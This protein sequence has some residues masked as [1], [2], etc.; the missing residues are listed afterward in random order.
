M[1]TNT[2]VI[3]RLN[4]D[5]KNAS[6]LLSAK[7]AR[8][9]V[10]IYYSVQDFRMRADNQV[11]SLGDEEP[12]E[13]LSW[14]F[15]NMQKIEKDIKSALGVFAADYSVGQWLQ[16]ICGIGPVLSAG[17]LATFDI[18]GAKTAGHYWRFAGQDPTLEWASRDVAKK[19]VKEIMGEAK[20]VNDEHLSLAAD[21]VG[22]RPEQLQNIFDKVLNVKKNKKS[23][24]K[25]DLASVIS[26]RPWNSRLK[27]LCWKAGESFIKVQSRDSD[28]YGKLF[29][30]RKE[31]EI[32]KND[33]GE[34]SDQARK[35]LETTKI[36]KSTKA[37]KFYSEGR[38]PPDHINSRARR[39]AVKMFLSHLHH[40][41]Y[42]D[43]YQADP[44]VPFV[45]SKNCNEDHRHY[46][47]PPEIKTNGK[48]LRDLYR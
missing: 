11:R 47:P 15:G 10:D 48:S 6:R 31:Q 17:F 13:V 18:R 19:I 12:G 2:D 38:L 36:S 33:A 43:Y 7:E 26:M 28:I 8:Y 30:K 21:K 42:V 14:V 4:K 37:Y 44:P 20:I 27:V 35:K 46:I 1:E 29:V 22:R 40:I 5:L 32:R 39:Y 23:M 41:S 34:F 25:A 16:G 24:N 3:I 45:F 9:L